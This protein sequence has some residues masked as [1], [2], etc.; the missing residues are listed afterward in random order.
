MCAIDA[1]RFEGLHIRMR[2][3]VPDNGSSMEIGAFAL[4][5]CP[6][7]MDIGRVIRDYAKM[8]QHRFC[9]DVIGTNCERRQARNRALKLTEPQ[10]IFGA[11]RG[12]LSRAAYTVR[13]PALWGNTYFEP[14]LRLTLNL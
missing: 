13:A 2:H 14:S 6:M 9:L 5:F 8:E 4:P 3:L 11:I 1:R 12:M 10:L 7:P